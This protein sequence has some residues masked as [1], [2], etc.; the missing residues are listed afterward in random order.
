MHR[1][2]ILAAAS[3]ICT[4]PALA[5][6]MP[7]RKSGLWD[8]KVMMEGVGQAPP[9]MQQC[10]DAKTDKQ[11]QDMASGISKEKC[12]KQE[13]KNSGGTITIDSICTMGNATTTSRAVVIGDFNSAYTMKMSSKTEGGPAGMPP[14]MNMTMEAKWL[15][16]CKADQKPG[17][18]IMGGMKMNINEMPKMPGAMPR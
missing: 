10:I 13:L 15:G 18:M 16:P 1:T 12:S 5:Q 4:V 7:A 14:Q 8:I 17:D 11:M 2:L 9:A 3:L 6:D